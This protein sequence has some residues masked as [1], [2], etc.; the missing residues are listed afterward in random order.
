MLGTLCCLMN[1]GIL[2][3]ILTELSFWHHHITQHHH[4]K[5][6]SIRYRTH[7]V[8]NFHFLFYVNCVCCSVCKFRQIIE[9][10]PFFM[11]FSLCAIFWFDWHWFS[12]VNEKSFLSTLFFL[13]I[14]M[15]RTSQKLKFEIL[16]LVT[17]FWNN[18]NLFFLHIIKTPCLLS[19][20]STLMIHHILQN[21][22]ISNLIIARL[23]TELKSFKVNL[24][25]QK[26]L[27]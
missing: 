15:A 3:D 25:P 13:T 20:K 9:R 27:A 12:T 21:C 16:S 14:W 6:F 23:E 2:V 7:C 24:F 26:I 8:H 11:I 1:K 17:R 18:S 4:C 5:H 19:T 22:I 10:M